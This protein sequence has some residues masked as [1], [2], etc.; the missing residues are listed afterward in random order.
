M[1]LYAYVLEG[2]DLA[3]EDSYVKLQL[4]K[5]KSKTRVLKNT[6]N[7]VWNEEFAFRV[8]DME[9]ELVVSVY[10]TVEGSGFFNMSAD[11][12]GRVRVPIGSVAAEENHNLPATWFS[13]V[14]PKGSRSKN[15][16]D[17]G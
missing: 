5:F 14:K 2:R 16:R 4:G 10:R 7:P 3:V 1:R 15:N 11:L 17:C 8:H 13:L 6:K 9:D 12:V